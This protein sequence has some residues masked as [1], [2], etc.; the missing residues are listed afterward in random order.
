MADKKVNLRV[1]SPHTATDKRPF[2]L[3]KDADMVILR[4][5][6][7]DLGVLTGRMPC[8]MVLGTGVLRILDAGKEFRMA[9][10]GGV[11]HVQDDVVTV[12]SDLALLPNDIDQD[13]VSLKI[14]NLEQQI[15][16]VNDLTEKD[17]LKSE[18][19]GLRIQYEV[20]GYK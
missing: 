10:M 7:G 19:K 14:K 16:G 3:Q 17:R 6:T 12:L 18:L 13:E 9:V 1:I 2:K 20:A 8:S 5:T 4:C 11:A 15:A